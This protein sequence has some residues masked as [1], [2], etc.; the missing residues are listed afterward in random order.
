MN[1]SSAFYGSLLQDHETEVRAAIIKDISGVVD[2][3]GPSTFASDVMPY[4]LALLQDVNQVGITVLY[5][6]VVFNVVSR[7]KVKICMF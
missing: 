4:V 7:T 6:C 3:V 2:L 5:Y 1:E